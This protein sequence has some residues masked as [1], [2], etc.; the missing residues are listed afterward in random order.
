[1]LEEGPQGT[2]R[3]YLRY[4]PEGEPAIHGLERVSR[5][6]RRVYKGVD[7]LP[8]V[9]RGIGVAIVST[10]QGLM[11]DARARQL[12]VGGEVVCTVW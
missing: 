9:R 1:V 5:P 8:Q 12:R 10:S 7:E 4:S 3:L 6:G 11:T 2:I